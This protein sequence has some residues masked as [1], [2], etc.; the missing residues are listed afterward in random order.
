MNKF[1]KTRTSILTCLI[2]LLVFF[3]FIGCGNDELLQSIWV[4]VLGV[5]FTASPTSGVARLTVNFTDTSSGEVTA[6]E[7]DFDND[8]TVD[9]TEQNPTY[10]FHSP[11]TY[12]VRLRTK[13]HGAS[14]DLVKQDLIHVT[15]G[16]PE[17]HTV[18][19]VFYDVSSIAVADIDGDGAQ[20]VVGGAES[21]LLDQS[22]EAL[23]WFRN[24]DGLG[25]Q[26]NAYDIDLN[27]EAYAIYT[28]DLD[29]DDDIDIVIA[30]DDT[31]V[32]SFW[33][34]RWWEN[35]NG[36][37][38]SWTAHDIGMAGGDKAVYVA[39]LDND[40]DLNA[41]S[42]GWGG[43]RITWFDYSGDEPWDSYDVTEGSMDNRCPYAKSVVAAHID[44]DQYLDI[45]AMGSDDIRWWKN[46][47]NTSFWP[48]HNI[49]GGYDS[50]V[51]IAY[52]V[53]AA[54]VD[55]DGD[56]DAISSSPGN[57][58]SY[59]GELV[60]WE[61]SAG[62]GSS[63][64]RYPIDAE[65]NGASL[66]PA[67]IDGDGDI[68]VL[69][70]GSNYNFQQTPPVPTESYIAWWEN[71]DGLGTSWVEHPIETDT[72]YNR[73]SAALVADVDSDGDLD[74]LATVPNYDY[75]TPSDPQPAG[76]YIAWWEILK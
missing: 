39:D 35:G 33:D 36:L 23:R 5:N 29:K 60:W 21:T 54:D 68:D 74:V 13:A 30:G 45:I 62:D 20:D 6:W 64:Q 42:A 72:S 47:N 10:R 43:D 2:L 12:S 75:S 37:G 58:P 70:V 73:A 53:Q 34:T 19:S 71:S 56:I 8:G 59:D 11:G 3:Y 55:G 40:G 17:K 52:S 1:G 41:V 49:S 31:G 69:G 28:V 48:V 32:G 15:L 9:S 27:S 66:Y 46:M 63:W 65:V 4:E 57:A 22:T 38:T 14:V 61:N 67:D 7:W 50:D 44:G 76:G 25:T 18:V 51:D 16:I 24:T 26:W